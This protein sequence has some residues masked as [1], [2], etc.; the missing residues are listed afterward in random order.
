MNDKTYQAALKRNLTELVIAKLE[1]DAYREIGDK[2]L[3]NF[4]DSFFTLAQDALFNDMIAH[5]IKV[6]DQNYQSTT[7][8]YIFRCRSKEAKEFIKRENID[9]MAIYD[10]AEKLKTI[11]DKTHF[12]IDKKG[13]K[14]P[15]VVWK[16]ANIKYDEF[17][18]NIES[19]YKILNHLHI[20]EFDFE[21]EIPKIEDLQYII[22]TVVD[23]GYAKKR[24]PNRMLTKAENKSDGSI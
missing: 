23:A 3:L 9:F 14:D 2:L 11:R 24:N 1:F 8:W 10:L 20:K 18:E 16:T 7:F 5:M 13:V 22:N 6:L 12:H 4:F 21:F 15:K 19:I 17:P